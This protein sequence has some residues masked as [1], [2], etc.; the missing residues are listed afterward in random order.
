MVSVAAVLDSACLI[1]LE[2]IG[3]RDIVEQ[4]LQAAYTPPT[5]EREFGAKPPWFQIV[6]PADKVLDK[7]SGIGQWPD[8]QER[9]HAK[10]EGKLP[11]RGAKSTKGRQQNGK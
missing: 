1:G 11:Q 4:L 8:L 10:G 3:R 7:T 9:A 2:N 6:A 5:V